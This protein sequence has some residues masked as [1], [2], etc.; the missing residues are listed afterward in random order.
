[1]NLEDLKVEEL[2][3]VELSQEEVVE[4]EGGWALPWWF[5][6][7]MTFG[8]DLSIGSVTGSSYRRIYA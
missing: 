6:P 8:L 7:V 5:D 2:G 3:L 1:M 4:V